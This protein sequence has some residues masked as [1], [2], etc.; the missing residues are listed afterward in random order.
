M[1]TDLQSVFDLLLV[2]AYV[3]FVVLGFHKGGQ[4]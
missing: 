4:R 2:I 1:E 3:F